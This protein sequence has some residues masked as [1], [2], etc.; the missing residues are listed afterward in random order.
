[1]SFPAASLHSI[2]LSESCLNVL[3][4]KFIYKHQCLVFYISESA[5]EIHI[6]LTS[7]KAPLGLIRAHI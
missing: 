6:A 2:A 5:E 3:E 4:H 7:D 1:M